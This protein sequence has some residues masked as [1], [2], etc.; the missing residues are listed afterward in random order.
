MSVNRGSRK[1]LLTARERV[2]VHLLPMQKFAQD[3][4]VPRS[5]TQDGIAEAVDVGRNNVAKILQELEDEKLIEVSTRHVKGLPSVRKVY[6][7]T[8]DGFETAKSLKNEME[9]LKIKVIDL[10]GEVHEDEVG[11][12]ASYIPGNYSF[13]ELAKGIERGVFDCRYFHESKVKEE[14]RFVDFTDKKPAVHT[15]FGREKEMKVLMD[16]ITSDSPKAAVIF[17]IPGIGKT[18]LIAKFAQEVRDRTNVFWLKVHEWVN[19]KGLLRPLAEFLSQSGKKNLEWYLGQT[20]SPN[21][22]EVLQIL[23]NDLRNVPTLLIFDDVQKGEEAVKDLVR[24]IMEVLE[25]MQSVRLVCATRDLPLFY[26]R[27]LVVQNKVREIQLEG[28]DK[29]SCVKMLKARSIPDDQMQQL[30]KITEGHPLFLELIEDV[31]SAL[32]KNIR[33]F[34]DQEVISKLDVAEKR[35]MNVAAVFRY[36]VIIDAFFITEEEMRK[37]LHGEDI[38][39]EDIDYTISYETVD[40]L[41][42]KSILHES[43]GRTIG[44]HD[45]LREFTYS[46]LTP[47]QKTMYHRAASKFYIQDSSLSSQVEALYHCIMGKELS[48]A[49]EIAAGRGA[50]IVR[51]GYSNQFAPLLEK[52]LEEP[53]IKEREELLLLHADVMD[54]RGEYEK[55]VM[56]YCEAI[57][58]IPPES[59]K[60]LLA[61]IHRK[62]GAIEL[63]R[64]RYDRSM[65]SLTLALTMATESGDPLTLAE[66]HYDL[67]GVYERRGLY[68][69]AMENFRSAEKFAEKAG[70]RTALGRA[71]YGHGRVRAGLSDFERAVD[72]KK[73]SLSALER[74]GDIN[75][76]AKACIGLANDLRQIGRT[77]EALRYLEKAVDLAN[78]IGDV[79]TLAY[80]LSNMAAEYLERKDLVKAEALIHRSAEIFEK[81]DD[82]MMLAST[83]MFKGF[84]LKLRGDWEWSKEEFIQSIQITK[85]LDVPSRTCHWIFEISKVYAEMGESSEAKR[86]F[87]EAKKVAEKIGNSKLMSM[88]D[89]EMAK[90]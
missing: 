25:D 39:L 40:S 36:P 32:G 80:A 15:F 78:S 29:E 74:A 28:L 5:V 72:L 21:V 75:M 43:I 14:R 20:E 17:G 10:K 26:S 87:M 57:K 60:R 65:E 3:A 48:K 1:S 69:L 83:H 50:E 52:L 79:S 45:L 49:V 81:I 8:H 13:L 85:G 35:I 19:V 27:S 77:D 46:R 34:I 47:R 82:K 86:L 67:G 23:T 58:L 44:M 53:S 33:M 70:N 7:L 66:V 6:F 42:A 18:T 4:N 59:E 22:G 61:D 12:L 62:I 90:L 88:V 11:K 51:R 37:D 54:L 2:L 84:L 76:M 73:S 64:S 38:G 41:L 31:K 56:E 71:L 24:A 89:E 68:E 55:A 63:K 30:I 9:S 16:L